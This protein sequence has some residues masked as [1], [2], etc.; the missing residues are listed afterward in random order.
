MTLLDIAFAYAVGAAL[1]TII[2]G[3]NGE[4]L[5]VAKVIGILL[6]PLPLL[7]LVGQ[8]LRRMP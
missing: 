2:L 3:V 5:E 1:W 8:L 7:H 4:N 6:W